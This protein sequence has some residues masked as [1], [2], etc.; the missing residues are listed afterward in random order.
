MARSLGA[1]V[2][3]VTRLTPEY[4]RAPLADL[5]LRTFPA[6]HAPRFANSYDAKGHRSQLLLHG[7]EPL[8]PAM[9]QCDGQID[10]FILAP[11]YHEVSTWPSPCARVRG[12]S[13][14]GILRS[15][16]NEGRV[17]PRPNATEIALKFAHRG[18]IAFLSEED[19]RDAESV[20][21]SFAAT[22]GAMAIVTRG[23][24]GVVVF[25]HHA[26]MEHA[27]VPANPTDPTGAGDCFATAYIVRLTETQDHARAMRF[28][29]VAGALAVEN[30]GIAGIPTRVAIERRLEMVAA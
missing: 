12:V 11:A 30:E 28:A 15:A 4:D 26:R 19:T 5:T 3:L 23:Y 7:G 25:E 18:V 20:A 14:Q 27:A 10:A 29:L 24:R 6:Q 22:P 2:Q 9:L 13:L 16:D 21:E 17:V 8:S 1:D